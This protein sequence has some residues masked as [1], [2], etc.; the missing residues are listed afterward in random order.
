MYNSKL[1]IGATFYLLGRVVNSKGLISAAEDTQILRVRGNTTYLGEVNITGFPLCAY[2]NCITSDQLLPSRLGC[3]EPELT[4]SCFCTQAV[5]PLSCAPGGPSDESNCWFELEDWF[6]G[7]CNK[8]VPL[9]DP[10]TLPECARDCVLTFL[11]NEGCASTTRNC[12]CILP[13]APIVQAAT[14]CWA[15]N[16]SKKKVPPFSPSSW[17]DNICSLGN[18][19]VYD[20]SGYDGYLRMVHRVRLAMAILVGLIASVSMVFGVCFC[21]GEHKEGE[22]DGDVTRGTA[23]QIFAIALVLLIIVPVYTAQ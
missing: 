19:T 18:T 6:A 5:T 22:K 9:I 1:W 8:S 14:N 23:L 15:A 16:C 20:Q 10:T 21:I 17:H 11:I 12:F 2:T 4:T 7:A 13:R 3:V